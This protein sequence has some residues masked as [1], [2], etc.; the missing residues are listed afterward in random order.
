MNYYDRVRMMIDVFVDTMS[1]I[2]ESPKLTAAMQASRSQTVVYPAQ[3]PLNLPEPRWESTTVAVT[4]NRSFA[5]AACSHQRNP[6]A[7]IG[8]LNF[9][10][11]THAGGGVREGSF[12]QEESLCRCSTLYPCLATPE[13]ETAYYKM[14]R[15]KRDS[16]YTD[17]VIYTPEVIV[18]KSDDA[19][20]AR[21]PEEQWFS[22]DVLTCAAPNL[23]IKPLIGSLSKRVTDEELY[24]IHCQRA[25]R[26]LTV[27]ALHQIDV[28]IL[29]AFGC[30][31]FQ[32][33]PAVVARAYHDVL[34]LFEGQFERIEFAV[35]CAS[36]DTT[37]Y[38][39]FKRELVTE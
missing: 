11:A 8:V 21:L 12:A 23:R 17:T 33:N 32:N 25:K 24:E 22:V 28:L 37:N 4:R 31:A 9:A 34:P 26:I 6:S 39:S 20:L 14:H 30:G 29:G 15:A 1:W 7:K 10:S 5:A 27:A 2:E 36:R 3:M 38:V 16:R 18:V 19:R 35:F 13:L